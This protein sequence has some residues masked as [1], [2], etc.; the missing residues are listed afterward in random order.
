[1]QSKSYVNA[2]PVCALFFTLF[3]HQAA[4]AQTVGATFGQVVTLGGTPSDI[5]LDEAR[6]KLYLVRSSANRV[7]VY[8]IGAKKVTAGIP[9][10]ATPYAAA[11]SVDGA[12]LYVSNNGSS[13]VSVI[14]LNRQSLIQTTALP[15]RPEGIEAGA[16]GRVLITTQGTGTG[17]TQNT[18]L[19]FDASQPL[20]QQVT[21]VQFPP[22]PP[23]PQ[24]APA[25]P[26]RATTP[27]KGRLKRTPDGN[28]IV[29]VSVTN[30]NSVT[31]VFVYEALS[32]TILRSRL[33]QGQSSTLSMSP[34]GSKFMAGFTL[35]DTATLAILGQMR[36][37]NA[38][39]PF[40][41]FNAQNN[42]GGSAFSPDGQTLYAAFNIAPF[43]QPP[44]RPQASTLLV[45]DPANL[46]IRL[47][48]KI[49]ESIVSK[50]V[51]TSDGANAWGLSESGLIY[52]PLSTLYEHPLLMPDTNTVFLAQDDC[53]RGI[54]QSAVKVSNIGDG[55]LTF[56]VPM[57]GAAVVAQ[58]ASGLAPA[59][60]NFTMDPGRSNVNRQPGTN[61]YTG[62]DTNQGQAVSVN[63]RSQEAINVPN[64]IRVFMN[65][66]QP[67]QRGIVYPVPTTPAVLEGLQDIVLDEPRNRVYITNSGFNRIEV[68]DTQKLHFLDPIPVG[69]L[70]HQMAMSLDGSTLYVGNTGGESIQMI[71][72]D[73]RKVIGSVNFP[74]IPRSANTQ[75]N[76]VSVRTLAMG[77]S[78]LNFVMSNGTQWQVVGSDAV[79]RQPNSI[80]VSPTNA[81]SNVLPG[82][83]QMIATPGGEY[84]FTM[85][86]S[87]TVYLF[88][89]SIDNYTAARQL[90]NNPITG[91][92]GALG[93]AP[94]GSFYLAN[95][96]VLNSAIT[97]NIL[98]PGQRNVAAV[99]PVDA[100]S[101]VRLTT[102]VR[103]GN[104]APTRDDPRTLLELFNLQAGGE[105]LVGPVAENPKFEVF[106]TQRISVPPRQ[107]VVD[108][109]G[110]VYAITISGLSVIPLAPAGDS[111]RPQLAGRNAVLNS[112][113]GTQNFAPGSFVTFSGSNLALSATADQLPVPT[114][115]GGSCVVIDNVA[116]PLLQTSSGQISAQIPGSVNPGPAVV[117]VRSLAT[118][119][120][121]DPLVITIGKP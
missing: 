91:Y 48:I 24:G 26:A 84:I 36:S 1:M 37:E 27:F 45:S 20:G 32:G 21:P 53:N 17:N 40:N 88:D 15:A 31:V 106:G 116:L 105:T 94:G 50:L 107:M 90:F 78:G 63:L 102:P 100:N 13:T 22:P 7:D 85:N 10:G 117:Q 60:V 14:D 96:A 76:P 82:P 35:Y 61:L 62:G 34:D 52:L 98:D 92:Y 3:F 9:V 39:F 11:M 108:S 69:Q 99:A 68:F 71:D 28:F 115:L 73:A 65:Y 12:R 81:S 19:I 95:G 66:R 109:K 110:T 57:L 47:G 2:G 80:A 54:A 51:I 83:V 87:G 46:S 18:L 8:D 74:P 6:G 112:N 25:V 70:P 29:G 103:T 58:A 72:L 33:V 75:S 113:D 42:V 97:Q 55:K 86:G 23:T 77:L 79:L 67:D 49:P 93:A 43:T 89:A 5:V 101:F 44:T 119:Q 4:E 114:V 111:T 56:S 59:A 38:P 118:A 30:N 121:S 64:T 120:Q 16:D 104:G 41:T